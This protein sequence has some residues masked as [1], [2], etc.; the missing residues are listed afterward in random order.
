MLYRGVDR[1]DL[2]R[3]GDVGVPSVADLFV[4]VIQ[5]ARA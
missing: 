3:L 4:A 5:G 2:E 1:V